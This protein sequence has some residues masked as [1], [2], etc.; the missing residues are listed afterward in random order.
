MIV[1]KENNLELLLA[2]PVAIYTCDADGRIEIYNEAAAELWGR[3]PKAGKDQWCGSWK[4]YQPDGTPLP[5]DQCPMA[6]VLKGGKVSGDEE[7]IIERP[8]GSRRNVMPHPQPIIDPSGNITGAVNMLID[9]TDRKIA[10]ENSARLAAIVQSSS[11]AIISKTLDGIITS[12]NPAAERL[13]GYKNEEMIGQHILKLIPPDRINEEPMI[14][15]RLKKGEL[16]DHFETKRL[17]KDGRLLDISLTISP[18]RDRKG[19]IIGASKIARDI[20]EQAESRKKIQESEERFKT[21]TNATPVGLWMTDENGKNS[22]INKTWIQWTSIPVEKQYGDGW[23]EAVL[24]AD[25]DYVTKKFK[26]S[27]LDRENFS[28]EFRIQRKNGQVRWVLSDGSPYYDIEGSFAG[29]AGSVS[30]ITERKQEELRKNEFF[31]VASHELKTP[32]TAIKAYAQLL[33]NTN[34]K[35]NDVFLKNGLSK[36]ENQVNKMTK[37]IG[38]FLNLSKIETNKLELN[39]EVFIINDLVSEIAADMQ[40][41][42]LNHKIVVE[43]CTMVKVKA[44]GEKISQVIANFLTNAVKYSPADKNIT[45]TVDQENGHAKV[46]VSDKGPGIRQEEQD[47]IFERFYRSKFNNN[48]SIPGFGIGLYISA[49]I[50][51]RHNGK[52]GVSSNE[53]EG[54]TFYFTLPLHDNSVHLKS[55]KLTDVEQSNDI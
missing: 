3:K 16:V 18:V 10:E 9:I 55:A 34:E 28:A 14:L 6:I 37:L 29:Y 5:L 50:I 24:A 26:Q 12:W 47:K 51:R 23:L 40:M 1:S 39:K 30:D 36:M 54:A 44:D 7:I 53:G 31:A 17:T 20:T 43:K 45:I 11:D 25:K 19:K 13:F 35:T 46:S 52:I 38:D 42:S 8:D 32:L 2:L 22:F 15:E 48:T 27:F 33:T 41:V 49:E 4:I 21:I